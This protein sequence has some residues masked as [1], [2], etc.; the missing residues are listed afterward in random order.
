MKTIDINTLAREN[1]LKLRPYSSARDEFQGTASL[2][3]DANEIHLNRA[4]T[5][6]R[7]RTKKH[8]NRHWL[9]PREFRTINCFWATAAMRPL[10]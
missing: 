3:L 4:T 8:L 2:F 5:D 6:I 7:I 1:V 9:R 10:I